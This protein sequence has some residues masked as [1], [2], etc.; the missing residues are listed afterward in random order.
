MSQSF[1]TNPERGRSVGPALVALADRI[2]VDNHCEPTYLIGGYTGFDLGMSFSTVRSALRAVAELAEVD[3]EFESHV[4]DVDAP[5][6]T[7][8]NWTGV[9]MG[10]RVQISAHTRPEDGEQ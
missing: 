2:E 9:F 3:F 6:V 7:F 4:D 10:V 5:T 1:A 8:H